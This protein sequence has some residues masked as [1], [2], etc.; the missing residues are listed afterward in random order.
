MSATGGKEGGKRRCS[1]LLR[2]YVKCTLFTAAVC[3]YTQPRSLVVLLPSSSSRTASV[4]HGGPRGAHQRSRQTTSVLGCHSRRSLG[5]S[6]V[7]EKN[8]AQTPRQAVRVPEHHTC[9]HSLWVLW[10]VCKR[11]RHRL[12]T[13]F[14]LDAV[15]HQFHRVKTRVWLCLMHIYTESLKK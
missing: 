12:G 9:P 1:L 7:L 15:S 4:S 10:T 6:K 14:R 8:V 11:E 5:G 2:P 13:R 3:T